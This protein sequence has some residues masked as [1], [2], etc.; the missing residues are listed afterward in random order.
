MA[1][2]SFY[3]CQRNGSSLSFEAY[4]VRDDAE[5]FVQAIIMLQ[6]HTTA[7]Y[8]AVWCGERSICLVP[9]DT[10]CLP[11]A[12]A[13]DHRFEARSFVAPAPSSAASP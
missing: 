12:I 3:P 9:R 4:D 10:N 2:Y 1:L 11:A 8:V 6:Q 5:A 13:H 7:A